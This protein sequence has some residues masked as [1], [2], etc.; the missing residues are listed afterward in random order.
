MNNYIADHLIVLCDYGLD[1][2]IATL[3]LFENHEKFGKIDIIAIA[4]NL[5]AQ[6]SLKNLR[7]LAALSHLP[8]G[9][10]TIVETCSLEQPCENL[11]FVHGNDGMGDL[12]SPLTDSTPV[13]PFEEYIESLESC[14]ILLSLGPMTVTSLILDKIEPRRFIFM[15]GCV[16]GT[17]NYHG[18]EFNHGVNPDAFARCVKH[19]HEGILLD[20]IHPFFDLNGK[21]ISPDSYGNRLSL[22]YR[23]FCNANGEQ[24]SYVWDDIAVY[25]LLNS[26]KF[27]CRE[28][29]DKWGNKITCLKLRD[30]VCI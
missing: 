13:I 27:Y 3:H 20:S 10:L 15:A 28:L 21:E 22:R 30:G 8:E 18:Y 29:T 25:Y 14:D 17:P 11:T 19:R 1:D 7:T 9:K 4:G 23:D 6:V 16:N 12:I 2:A 24:G 26:E 5:S